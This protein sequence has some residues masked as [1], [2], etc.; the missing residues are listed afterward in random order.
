MTSLTNIAA[1]ARREYLVRIGTRSFLLGTALLVLGVVAI[2]LLPVIVRAIEGA[3]TTRVAVV[4]PSEALGERAS[5]TIT[6]LLNSSVVGSSDDSTPDFVV[7]VVDDLA[8]ARSEALEGTYGAVLG[9]DRTDGGELAFTLYTN[10]SA[11]GRTAGLIQQ[12]ANAIAIGDRLDR[13]GVASGDQATLFAPADFGVGWPDP[14]RTDP[15][16][17]TVAA[18]I[19]QDMLGFGM[20]ILIFMIIIMYG[21]WIAM[22]VV[23]EK[24]SRVMEVV[25][26]AATPFQLMAGKVFGVGAVAL[27]QYGAIVVSG[28]LALVLQGTIAAAVLGDESASAALPEGL[29]I[30]LLLVFGV[31]GVLGFLLYAS[32]FAAAG[33]LVSRQEDVNAAVMPMTLVSTG[34]YLI[35]VYAATGLLD[36]RAGWIVALSQVP[37]VS[38]FMML[39]RIATGAAEPWE[40]VLSVGLL[41]VAIAGA[42][43]LASRIYRAGVLLYGQ[44]PGLAAVWRMVRA[45]V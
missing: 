26:N 44:R 34:G 38:P 1:V 21:N 41:V 8:V 33:S 28:A 35:G 10:D 5:M 40:I 11:T 18:T 27:T 36:I 23:E 9:I 25:L 30:G 13:L 17:E 29:T 2:A 22:S 31:Y 15:I 32:L 6:S 39:G 24:S 19:G 3:S 43:W 20:T 4:A 14:A 7:T 12:G 16:E 45:G 42:L 37:F